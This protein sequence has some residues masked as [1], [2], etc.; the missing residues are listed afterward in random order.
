MDRIL[1]LNLAKIMQ[2]KNIK[3]IATNILAYC[4]AGGVELPGLVGRK[5]AESHLILFGNT[6]ISDVMENLTIL[7]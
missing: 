7:Q 1:A 3:Q 2:R 5:K 6:G 4:H